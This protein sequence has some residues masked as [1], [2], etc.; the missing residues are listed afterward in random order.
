MSVAANFA[1]AFRSMRFSVIVPAHNEAR[2]LPACL[3]ALRRAAEF[4]RASVEMIVVLN[5]CTDDTE[6]IALTAGAMIVREDRRCLAA[7]RNAGARAATGEVIVTVDADSNVSANL[8]AEVEQLLATGR[9]VGGGISLRME[10]YSLGIRLTEAFLKLAML[11]TGLSGGVYWSRLEDF[12]AV[13]GFDEKLPFGEDMDFAKRLRAHGR[14][15]GRRFTTLRRAWIVTSC[16]KFD[17]F[18]DWHWF[19]FLLQAREIRR[20]MRNESSEFKDRYFYEFNDAGAPVAG[21]K[22]ACGSVRAPEPDETR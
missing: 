8:F 19:K 22:S 11:C 9:F 1:P 4:N 7:I 12:R 18:G 13:G 20:S 5:R 16:R 15:S 21:T 2:Y 10:R 3:A 17:R 14:K 6:R